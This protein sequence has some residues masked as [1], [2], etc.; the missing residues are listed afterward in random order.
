MRETR[1]RHLT[2]QGIHITEESP[3]AARRGQPQQSAVCQLG[4]RV[5]LSGREVHN[6]GKASNSAC[7]QLRPLFPWAST[8]TEKGWAAS[9]QW[10]SQ[11]QQQS[12]FHICSKGSLPLPHQPN[13]DTQV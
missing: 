8:K 13:P 5:S 12:P 4:Q 7:K 11:L 3:G 9:R 10:E 1:C 6:E 2:H